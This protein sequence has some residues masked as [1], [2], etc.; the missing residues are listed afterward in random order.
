[1]VEGVRGGC[2]AVLAS[3]VWAGG[4][5]GQGLADYDYENL[6][7]GGFGIEAGWVFPS[8]LEG[9]PSITARFDLGLLGPSFRLAS[10]LS[11]W[12]TEFKASEVTEFEDRLEELIVLSDPGSTPTVD[13]GQLR[14]S[15][16]VVGVDGQYVWSGNGVAELFIG[17]GFSVHLMNGDGAA[18]KDTFVEDLL[19]RVTL[20]LNGHAGAGF[21]LNSR[22][23][24]LGQIRYEVL[25]DL[26]YPELRAGGV[27]LLGGG[28]AR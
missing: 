22:F 6:S 13:L 4:L 3:V 20:G 17:S 16:V 21:Q 19:D 10:S 25:D 11:Y 15:D 7:V 2:L 12:S 1:M 9:T 5:S 18:I 8:R 23:Q 26:S 27:F 24:V 14:W 28:T